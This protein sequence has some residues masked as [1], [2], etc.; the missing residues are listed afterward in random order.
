MR[1]Y[2]RVTDIESPLQ[3]AG[4][5]GATVAL[6]PVELRDHGR[7]GNE[8]FGEFEQGLWHLAGA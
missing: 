8:R 4:G 7:I 3:Q 6:E 1:S 5:L 2:L